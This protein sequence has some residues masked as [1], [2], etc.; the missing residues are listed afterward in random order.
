ML[1][2]ASPDAFQQFLNS[3]AFLGFLGAVALFVTFTLNNYVNQK[4]AKLAIQANSAAVGAL[5]ST[6]QDHAAR[7][8]GEL[9]RRIDNRASVIAATTLAAMRSPEFATAI[10]AIHSAVG[11]PT[12]PQLNPDIIAA[13]DVIAKQATPIPAAAAAAAGSSDS[14]VATT[15]ARAVS[16][17]ASLDEHIGASHPTPPPAS[18][19]RG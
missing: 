7:L 2:I 19:E 8:N 17:S 5:A 6:V 10:S 18:P 4:K 11:G 13:I 16:A 1:I 15:A 3:P 12:L 14:Q 9:D